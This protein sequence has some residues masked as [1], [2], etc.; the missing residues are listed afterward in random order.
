MA[1]STIT[2]TLGGLMS[3]T[4]PWPGN[5]LTFEMP[6]KNRKLYKLSAMSS[7]GQAVEALVIIRVDNDG[8]AVYKNLLSDSTVTMTYSNGVLIVTLPKSAHWTY[9]MVDLN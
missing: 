1:S 7:A 8:T 6:I 3:S 2:K 4:D 5:T 9:S